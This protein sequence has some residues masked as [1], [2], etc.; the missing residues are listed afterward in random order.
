MLAKTATTGMAAQARLETASPV[1]GRQRW[2]TLA[3]LAALMGF[4]SISTDLYLPTMPAMTRALGASTG[5][6][7]WTVSGYLIG[8]S[9]GQLLWGPISD[10]F[11]RRG[12]SPPVSHYSLSARLDALWRAAYP[13][14]SDGVS[15][16]RWVP[17]RASC[18]PAPWCGTCILA[19]APPK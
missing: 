5:S 2:H 7:E 14:S 8:F 11:G 12:Q 9:F 1:M 15:F 6:V 3:I 18:W 17:A 13:R 19:H 10:R 4:A 16:R